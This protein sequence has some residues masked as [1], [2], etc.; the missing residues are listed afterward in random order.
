MGG[1]FLVRVTRDARVVSSMPDGHVMEP[2]PSAVEAVIGEDCTLIDVLRSL[3]D[4]LGTPINVQ[5]IRITRLGPPA[6]FTPHAYP[7]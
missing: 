3:E 7:E 6:T 2:A 1:R 5:E 4:Q